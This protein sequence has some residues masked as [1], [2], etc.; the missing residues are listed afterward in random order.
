MQ[1]PLAGLNGEGNRIVVEKNMGSLEIYDTKTGKMVYS[2]DGEY[3][4]GFSPQEG[5]LI[6]DNCR[7]KVSLWSLNEKNVVATFDGS[8]LG[9]NKNGDKIITY[10][11]DK[12]QIQIWSTK[13]GNLI[14][15]FDEEFSNGHVWNNLIVTKSCPTTRIINL[16]KF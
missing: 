11:W 16:E 1:G 14:C 5:L 8:L 12:H 2:L 3:Y 9:F 15:S 13:M 10:S 7:G 4:C 6:T